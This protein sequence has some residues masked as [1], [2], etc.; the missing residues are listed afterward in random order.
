MSSMGCAMIET[1]KNAMIWFFTCFLRITEAGKCNS[2]CIGHGE[3]DP[4]PLQLLRHLGCFCLPSKVASS[5]FC[6]SLLERALD[7][8]MFHVLESGKVFCFPC[9]VAI[10][11]IE[12]L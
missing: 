10:D 3:K 11:I 7:L 2:F 12:G 5:G 4:V 8:D 1:L 9:F 6:D